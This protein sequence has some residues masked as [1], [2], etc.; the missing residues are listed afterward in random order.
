M[1]TTDFWAE[2]AI[3][4]RWIARNVK[5]HG[6]FVGGDIATTREDLEQEGLLAA[7]GW[8][9]RHEEDL[10]ALASTS[11]DAPRALRGM[12][13][14]VIK[15]GYSVILKKLTGILGVRFPRRT[16]LKIS[17]MFGNMTT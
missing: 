9:S 6:N 5:L 12:L 16:G 3:L 4:S 2:A 8:I 10:A 7:A 11:E 1:D 13:Y 14:G 17:G 15:L